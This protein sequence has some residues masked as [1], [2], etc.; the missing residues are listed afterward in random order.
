MFTVIKISVA[1]VLGLFLTGAL[2][3]QQ[4]PEE[5]PDAPSAT[6]PIP[7][8]VAPSPRPGADDNALPDQPA[9]EN[10]DTVTSG[11]KELPHTTSDSGDTRPVPPPM[12]PIRSVPAG[13]IP[14]DKDT[15]AD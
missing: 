1:A 11:N 15:G 6:R 7:P 14:R 3:A 4:Q 8:P 5:I 9:A 10:P 2:V 13:S 12:P